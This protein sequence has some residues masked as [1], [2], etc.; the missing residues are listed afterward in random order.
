MK[1]ALTK[2]LIAHKHNG[3]RPHI[4]REVGIVA[5][6]VLAVTILVATRPLGVW[7]SHTDTGAA[8]YPAV[9]TDLA[10][11]HRSENN[12]GHLTISPVL[13]KAALLKA[14]DM[15][16]KGY[17]A[18]R[19]PEGV[20]P[21]HWFTEAGYSYIYAGENLA[22]DFSESRDI[23]NAWMNSPGHRAN[24][25]NPRYTE[26]GIATYEGIFE[27][28]PTIFVVEL[29]ASPKPPQKAALTSAA[30]VS[31]SPQQIKPV[32]PMNQLSTTSA[33]AGTSTVGSI[34]PQY[35]TWFE[36]IIS[37][38]SLIAIAAY[39]VLSLAILIALGSIFMTEIRIR[40]RRHITYGIVILLIM[41]LFIYLEW[42]A[43]LSSIQ[44]A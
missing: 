24:I 40:D 13:E 41:M 17:F 11:Q 22:I 25:L 15:A 36:R 8:V 39:T 2:L 5:V 3:Y 18:H 31:V 32:Q 30:A 16:S 29:F 14:R 10:N 28:K 19:S 7:I 38:P 34:I 6:G 35:S 43:V 33:V 27:G 9:L 42:K 26:I 44:I 21:W 37:Q 12:I 20:D 4:L 23:E 1:R